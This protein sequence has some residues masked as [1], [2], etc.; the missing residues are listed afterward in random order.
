MHHAFHVQY[1]MTYSVKK[2]RYAVV[3]SKQKRQQGIL[4]ASL[5]RV[6]GLVKSFLRMWPVVNT[7]LFSSYRPQGKPN[8]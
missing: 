8:S 7:V 6:T 1:V 4:S 2:S 5:H 3:S